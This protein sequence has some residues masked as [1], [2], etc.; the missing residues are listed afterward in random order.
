MTTLAATVAAAPPSLFNG[1]EHQ[2]T[3]L[4]EHVLDPIAQQ[5][6]AYLQE[7]KALID[8]LT[9]PLTSAGGNVAEKGAAWIKEHINDPRCE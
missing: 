7:S 3:F 2:L 8:S 4:S 9:G 6:A 1:Q 5:A